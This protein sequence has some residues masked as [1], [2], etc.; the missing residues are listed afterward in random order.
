MKENCGN[1]IWF[2]GEPTTSINPN[3]PV[4]KEQEIKQTIGEKIALRGGSRPPVY[5]K[6]KAVFQ[7]ANN[8]TQAYDFGTFSSSNCTA[9]DDL[10]YKLFRVG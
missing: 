1:C 6:C 7:D 5:G 10:G 2:K 4:A 3:A 9:T 8:E